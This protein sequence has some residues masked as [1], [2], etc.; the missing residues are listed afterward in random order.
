MYSRNRNTTVFTGNTVNG[1]II[2]SH[3]IGHLLLFLNKYTTVVALDDQRLGVNL[4]KKYR[5]MEHLA[6]LI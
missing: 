3:R 1:Y 2:M 4:E 5:K 6:V